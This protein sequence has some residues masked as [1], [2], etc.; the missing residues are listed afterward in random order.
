MR[1]KRL[2]RG[3]MGD[4]YE[5]AECVQIS[6]ARNTNESLLDGMRMPNSKPSN[7]MTKPHQINC[8]ESLT[9]DS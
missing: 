7:F 8:H 4:F 1:V 5:E 3:K 9:S 6:N 2:F